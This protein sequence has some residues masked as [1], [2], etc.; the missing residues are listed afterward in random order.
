MFS[1]MATRYYL[2]LLALTT[3]SVITVIAL[4]F[5]LPS[6]PDTRASV[7]LTAGFTV[8]ALISLLIFFNGFSSDRERSVFLT[9]IALGVKML[10]SF[11]LAL[12]YLLVFKNDAIGSIILFFVLY[13]AFTVY[14][15]FTFT[16]VLKKKSD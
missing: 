6:F 10:L 11:I 15:V 9:L 3:V 1:N 5:L 14:V 2:G 7:F 13:L 16:S 4:G 12:M 8:A